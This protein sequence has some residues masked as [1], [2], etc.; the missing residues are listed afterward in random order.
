[1]WDFLSA[2]LSCCISVSVGCRKGDA[3]VRTE[4]DV[5]LHGETEV[6]D[7]FGLVT[8]FIIVTTLL[9]SLSP[10]LFP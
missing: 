7:S 10:C 8:V 9:A 1:M 4:R 3:A 5:W 6:S 2:F